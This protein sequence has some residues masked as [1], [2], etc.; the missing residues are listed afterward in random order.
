MGLGKY[1][2]ANWAQRQL[3]ATSVVVSDGLSC[4]TAVA[5][6]GCEHESIVNGGGP[7]STANEAF[8]WVNTMI[9]N[10][11]KLDSGVATMGSVANHRRAISR[12]S[13]IDSTAASTKPPC[14]P[15]SD[16]S[17]IVPRGCQ[18]AY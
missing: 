13:L 16:V 14:F 7:A 4:F 18:N 2:G 8:T 9:G 17:G 10:V 6:A 15:A 5:T 1:E 12:S 3:R 11:K